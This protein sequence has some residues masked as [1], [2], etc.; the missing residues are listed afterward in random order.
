MTPRPMPSHS[1]RA[2][3]GCVML[4]P[5]IMETIALRPDH[6][7]DDRH[8]HT[9]QVMLGRHSMGLP[10]DMLS[11]VEGVEDP[12]LIA[13]VGGLCYL[14]SHGDVACIE[15]NLEYQV[16]QMKERTRRIN[17]IRELE[18]CAAALIGGDNTS[19]D[20]ATRI[21]NS[22]SGVLADTGKTVSTRLRQQHVDLMEEATGQ[23]EVYI[24]TG[25]PTWD[26]HSLF[27]GLSTEG[28]TLILGASGMG[29]TTLLNRYVLGLLSLGTCV[30]LHGSET[31]EDRRLR[32][33]T[34]SLAGVDGRAWAQL[35]RGL[36]DLKA[37]GEY[38]LEIYR[39]VEGMVSRLEEAQAWL[40]DKPLFITGAGKT[41]EQVTAH[42]RRIHRKHA[43]MVVVVDYLQDIADTIAPGVRVGDRIQQVSHK[44][45][46]LKNL[47]AHLRRPVIVG[48]QV[49]GEKG[50]PGLDPRPE[51]WDVQWSSTAHQ[52]AEEVYALFRA[53]Y[54]RDRDP[55]TRVQ[56][57]RGVVEVI[58]RKRR[59]GKL[60]TLELDFHGPTKWIGERI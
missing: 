50:G 1:E 20:V 60:A 7:A 8:I 54:Y 9:W 36:A 30:Y 27:G 19:L 57:A 38:D 29:K 2:I 59:T 31:S 56:G 5:H 14:S 17:L 42:A 28:V 24:R 46:Q 4:N 35:T 13:K 41:V 48:A 58:A 33:L 6:F 34:F 12:E 39:E 43:R 32:D 26:H 22:A 53:D 55:N 23:R 15:P 51:L 44:S 25:I 47:A 37:K 21:A 40:D 10:L 16:R 45:G 49:S 3:I 52:D 18:H 11:I